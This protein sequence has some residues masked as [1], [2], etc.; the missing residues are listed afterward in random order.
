MKKHKFG[1]ILPPGERFTGASAVNR[2]IFQ[3]I[4]GELKAKAIVA[5]TDE[6]YK[7]HIV[8]SLLNYFT[9][10]KEANKYEY[11]MGTSFATLPFVHSSKIVQHFHSVDTG[12]YDN[13][14]SAIKKQT[15]NERKV[16]LRWLN[17]FDGIFEEDLSQI[18]NRKLISEATESVCAKMSKKIIAVSP[19][20]KEQLIKL[21][22]IEPNKIEVILN[23]IPGYWFEKSPVD[24]ISE[25]S[26]V[27]PTRINYTTYTFLEK[28]QDRAFE[29]LSQ[30]TI[31]KFVYVNFGTMKEE[32]R[33][34]YK[35][36][37]E[38]KSKSNLIVGLNREQLQREYKAGQIFLS[39]SRT[40]ACQLTLIE[41]MTS[42]LCP[43]T[44]P[45]GIASTII[46]NG[47]N[48]YVVHSVEE[49]VKMINKLKGDQNLREKIGHNAYKTAIQNFTMS[50]MIKKYKST[51]KNILKD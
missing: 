40:E 28:G 8:G 32:I 49:A 5:D 12:S 45:V 27:F 25:T 23:G 24:F 21:F 20:V 37:I 42:K 26:V 29:I 16:M 36:V 50:D 2:D 6:F 43:I 31:P 47:V 46:K 18:D 9:N 14:L 39:T 51:L 19:S 10:Y 22:G 4:K 38:N 34:T 35:K 1:F 44:Y 13:V 7:I 17:F 41:A 30:V 48:G 11:V 33:E 15:R 3:S